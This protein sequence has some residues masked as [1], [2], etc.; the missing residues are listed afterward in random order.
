[1]AVEVALLFGRDL[2]RGRQIVVEGLEQDR[3]ALGLPVS[4][5]EGSKTSP[6]MRPKSLAGSMS[7]AGAPI[8]NLTMS[9]SQAASSVV[10]ASMTDPTSW[11]ARLANGSEGLCAEFVAGVVEA[12]DMS[13]ILGAAMAGSRLVRRRSEGS[14]PYDGIRGWPQHKPDDPGRD[15]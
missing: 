10:E 5:V 1:Q 12:V 6:A 8:P 2:V 13:D 11:S 4:E 9:W 3:L 14:C 7:G 15:G